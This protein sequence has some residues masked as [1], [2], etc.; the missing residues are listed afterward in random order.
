[1]SI[2]VEIHCD[3]VAFGTDGSGASMCHSLNG[4]QPGALTKDAT[5]VPEILRRLK[6]EA[7]QSGWS[8]SNGAWTCPACCN[9]LKS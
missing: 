5:S 3:L 1:M 9:S 2:R 7:I 4:K 6:N 8:Y